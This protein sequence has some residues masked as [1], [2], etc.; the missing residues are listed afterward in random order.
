MKLTIF[1]PCY[2]RAHCLT[3]LYESL[4]AQTSYDFEWLIIDDGSTDDTAELVKKTFSDEKFPIRYVYKENGGKHTAHNKALEETK[5]ELFLCVDSD[6]WL[7]NNAVEK[8]I[9]GAKNLGKAA[10]MLA[11]K[12]DSNNTLLSD[13]FPPDVL[14]S[15]ISE[16]EKTQTS[17]G[18]FSIILKTSIAKKFPFPS[19][20]GEKFIGECVVYDR[21]DKDNTFL[22]LPCV[23]TICEYQSDG[24]SASTDK[25]M[26][27]NPTGYCLYYKQRIDIADGLKNRIVTAGKY[28]AFR[29][30]SH[31]TLSSYSGDHKLLSAFTAPLGRIFWLYYKLFR[32]F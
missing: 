22:L 3:R 16:L 18:E 23:L 27:S 14:C 26:K 8:I 10:G 9:D 19:F 21:I 24:Y 15:K 7:K 28:H 11:Y 25:L 30:F 31:K 12:C 32:G 4:I 2:N 6:D 17:N 1:T 5:G 29:I 13:N 20:E